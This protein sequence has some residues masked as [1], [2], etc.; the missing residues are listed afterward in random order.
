M[1]GQRVHLGLVEVGNRLQVGR[2]VAV[3][4]EEALVVFEAVRRAGDRILQAVG[5]VV[6]ELLAGALLHVGGGDDAQIH[7]GRHA[8]FLLLA[9][10]AAHYEMEHVVA[11][12]ALRLAQHHLRAPARPVLREKAPDVLVAPPIAAR[13]D[14]D[15]RDVL[16]RR[17]DAEPSGDGSPQAQAVGLGVLL[18]HEDAEDVG[19]AESAH[20]ERRDHT[21]IDAA[22]EAEH[23]APAAQ[24]LEHLA[25]QRRGDA[26][27]LGGR[28]EI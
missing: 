12:G 9:V 8:R 2:A 7:L 5:V 14:Q 28:V 17:L 11:R 22:R 18:G 4:H 20:A 10:R 19:R 25:A 24:L 3:L 23:D 27:D 26:L 15:R 1:P 21:G 6:L 13:A 16:E